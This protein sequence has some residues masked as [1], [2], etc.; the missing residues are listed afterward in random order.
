MSQV[1][2]LFTRFCK[3]KPPYSETADQVP[4]SPLTSSADCYALALV[5]NTGHGAAEPL[6]LDH[7]ECGADAEPVLV[8]AVGE[9]FGVVH[10]SGPFLWAAGVAAVRGSRAVPTRCW[11]LFRKIFSLG[12]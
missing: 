8:D 3:A 12:V 10:G 9:V 11:T 5:G 4:D 6:I 1:M 2:A 7:A